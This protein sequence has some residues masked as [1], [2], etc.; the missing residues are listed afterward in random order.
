MSPTDA[1]ETPFATPETVAVDFR[2][3]R[4]N[5]PLIAQVDGSK[6]RPYTRFSSAAKA[7]E[8]RFNLEQWA[9][10]NVAFG[11]AHDPSL[12][13]TVLGIG[14]TPYTW[15]KA[16][17]DRVKDVVGRAQ[18]VA[19]SHRRADEGTAVHEM[20]E[21][22]DRGEL[23]T[24]G[25]YE[26]DLAAYR[27]ELQRAGVVVWPQWIE[28]RMVSDSLQMAGTADRIVSLAPWSPLLR[29]LEH[30]P[31]E[32]LIA[33]VKTGRS[34]DFGG[35]SIAAQLAGYASGVLYDP[36]A[37]VRLPTPRLNRR[38]GLVIHLPA[39]EGRCDLYKADL[40]NGLAAAHLANAIR[41]TRK[42]SKQWLAQIPREGN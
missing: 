39:G 10:R 13:A 27:H 16:E 21:R 17:K 40:V 5:R 23:V 37:E 22:N 30:D 32:A 35:L 38:W 20:T 9:Q 4:W 1:S 8:D 24:A 14:G 36:L 2:R 18:N 12:V 42:V 29:D 31:D 11:M 41:E 33:D 15:G 19:Q 34:L 6:A 7:L 28:C 25:P 26:P 3:D